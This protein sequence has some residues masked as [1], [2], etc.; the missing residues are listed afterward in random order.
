MLLI[1]YLPKITN[2]GH[3]CKQ[4]HQNFDVKGEKKL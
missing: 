2:L 1:R 3:L 4:K